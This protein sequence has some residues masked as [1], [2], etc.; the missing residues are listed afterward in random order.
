MNATVDQQT[1]GSFDYPVLYKADGSK[2]I[3]YDPIQEV[4]QLISLLSADDTSTTYQ[5]ATAKTWVIFKK[6]IVLFL[7][8]VCFVI[9]FPI[10]VSGIG[11][12]SGFHFR[13]W[14]EDEQPPLEKIVGLLLAYLAKPFQQAYAWASGFIESYLNLKVSFDTSKP[15]SPDPQLEKTAP[16]SHQ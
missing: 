15:K 1:P 13:K 9:A 7:F 6:A 4:N 12:Q 2:L 5:K 8:L 14:L 10:W 16:A 11:F 3:Q